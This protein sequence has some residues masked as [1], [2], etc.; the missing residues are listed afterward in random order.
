MNLR[1]YQ[2]QGGHSSGQSDF[3]GGTSPLPHPLSQHTAEFENIL[4]QAGNKLVVV[5]F[6]ATWCPPCQ[7]I[8]PIFVKMAE[9]PANNNVIF[10]KVDVD[11]ASDVSQKC[12]I[13]AMPT[14]QFYKNGQ[15]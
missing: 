5:D 10:L 8:G 12:G 3:R 9:D 7:M 2:I 4:S 1:T 11:D 13:R 15:K 6:T 14:F